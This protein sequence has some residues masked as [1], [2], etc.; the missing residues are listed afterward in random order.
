MKTMLL[1]LL[2]FSAP[3]TAFSADELLKKQVTELAQPFID[4]EHVVGMSIGVINDDE[5]FSVHVGKTD[6]NGAIPNDETVYEI[7]SVSKVFTGILAADA[8]VRGE[9]TLDQPL[10]EL[11]PRN[12]KM[13]SWKQQDITLKHLLTHQSGLPRLPNNMPSLRTNNPYVDYTSKL[14]YEFL[15]SHKLQNAPGEKYA[16]SNFAMALAGHLICRQAEKSYDELL[17][18]RLSDPLE[19]TSTRVELT[20]SMKRRFATPHA[21][22]DS[23]T[24]SWEFADQPGAGGIRSTVTD[25]LRFARA[26]LDRPSGK[27]GEALELAWKKQ[28]KRGQSPALGL[29]WH[30]SS[31]GKTRW[32]NGQTGGFHSMLRIN[33]DNE[34]A[35]IIL[36]NTAYDVDDLGRDIMDLLAGEDVKPK[37]F[38]KPIEVSEKVMQRYVGKYQLVPTFIFT[39]SIKDKKLMVGVTNQATHQVYPRSET[40][41][42]YKVVDATLK[43]QVDKNGKCNSLQLLQNGKTQTAKRIE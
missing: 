6:V 18:T 20:R 33:A 42:F 30:I 13:P 37:P 2:T 9:L 31:D 34:T 10:R 21:A 39:V 32:H 43:F 28:T 19:M 14:A 23:P 40:E 22:Y 1:A 3:L 17:R 35:V 8:V 5:Q 36:A 7:G 38:E 24:S 27:V 16:Y 4:A 29:G 41:W 15:N 26:N 25:M 11:L 12:V